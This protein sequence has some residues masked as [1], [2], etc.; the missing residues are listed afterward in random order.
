MFEFAFM[1]RALV[2]AVLPLSLPQLLAALPRVTARL[3][4]LD[5]G[6]GPRQIQDDKDRFVR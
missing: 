4:A 5:D 2:A 6:Y 1:Q 3:D